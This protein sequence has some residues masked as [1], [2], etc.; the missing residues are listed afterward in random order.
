MQFTGTIELRGLD[1]ALTAILQTA[2]QTAI[3][4]GETIYRERVTERYLSEGRLNG[5]PW[6]P[7]KPR[8][9]RLQNR[10]LLVSTGRLRAS[11]L[12][13]GS[14]DAIR[15]EITDEAGRPALLIGSNVPY[16][17]A[18]Q[19]GTRNLPARTIL[20]AEVLAG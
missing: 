11:F 16:A 13:P 12:D 8:N 17:S 5:T 4:E 15:Q 19:W 1:E 10:P 6:L 3:E 9:G 7:R 14:P 20:T 18:H 2:C